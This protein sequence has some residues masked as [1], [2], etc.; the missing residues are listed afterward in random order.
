ML[1]HTKPENLSVPFSQL[2]MAALNVV[3][4]HPAGIRQDDGYSHDPDFDDLTNR[5]LR[6]LPLRKFF[7]RS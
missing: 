4:R 7:P 1:D 2:K 5:G 3:S 6:F